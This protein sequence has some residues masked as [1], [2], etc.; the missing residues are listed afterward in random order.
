MDCEQPNGATSLDPAASH[1]GQLLKRPNGAG[2]VAFTG[3]R[4][5]VGSQPLQ[6]WDE[7][8]CHCGV[9]YDSAPH[10]VPCNRCQELAMQSI[11]AR[12]H[13]QPVDTAQLE[14]ACTPRHGLLTR[15][16]LGSTCWV[17]LTPV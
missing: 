6:V 8:P 5:Q 9:D 10:V 7:E 12:L 16:K 1:L 2:R 4:A 15:A 17:F 14:L 3:K 13:S 11:A